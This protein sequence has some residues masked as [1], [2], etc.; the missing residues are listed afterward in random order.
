MTQTNEAVR[1]LLANFP[2]AEL[3]S[4]EHRRVFEKIKNKLQES[5]D[6]REELKDLYRVK[7]LSDFATALMWIVD[8]SGKAPELA[9]I[10][11]EDK[12]LLLSS[13]RRAVG[14]AEPQEVS[15][16]APQGAGDVGTGG[17]DDSA[18]AA[19][20]EK[21]SEAVQSGTEGRSLL[22][23]GLFDEC[24]APPT[25]GQPDNFNQFKSLMAEF[26]KYIAENEL[27]DDVR[28]INI[29]S[30]ISSTVCQWAISPPEAR[31]GLMDE[32]LTPLRDF[33]T[34]FE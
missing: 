17:G 1:S 20:L 31:A 24:E 18:F 2:V 13:F 27:M 14:G 7:G 19:Q 4:E 21:F 34:H 28:V 25:P 12:T 8:R 6:A 22:L 15:P 10:T 33:K 23:E 3:A 11:P 5:S 16:A 9:A 29:F 32:A 26:L 30:N